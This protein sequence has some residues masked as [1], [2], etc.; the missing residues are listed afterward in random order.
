[1]HEESSQ[2]RV[3]SFADPEQ[4]LLAPGGIFARDDSEPGCELSPLFKSCSVA[5]RGDDCGR[6][7]RSD[8]RDRYQSSAGFV[9]SSRLFAEGSVEELNYLTKEMALKWAEKAARTNRLQKLQTEK[10]S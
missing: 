8:A 4:L 6:R 7:N 5:D 3:P 10:A 2:V 1:M 9:L